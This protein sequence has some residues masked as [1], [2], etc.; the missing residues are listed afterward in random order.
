[1][2]DGEA[3]LRDKLLDIHEPVLTVGYCKVPN[4]AYT[5]VSF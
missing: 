3:Y 2:T 4:E 1:M 5:L